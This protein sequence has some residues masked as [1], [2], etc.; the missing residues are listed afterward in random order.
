LFRDPRS[1][2]SLRVKSM[3]GRLTSCAERPTIT[4]L[5]ALATNPRPWRITGGAPTASIATDGPSPSVQAAT[6]ASTS[7]TP[8]TTVRFR[9]I[10][11]SEF[12]PRRQEVHAQ[13]A[14]ASVRRGE[15]DTG[16]D[17]ARSHHDHPVLRADRGAGHRLDGDRDRLAEGDEVRIEIVH[18]VKHRRRNGSVLAESPIDVGAQHLEVGQQLPRPIRQG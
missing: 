2:I 9:P 11:L 7:S 4:T 13:D 16:P 18:R 8:A 3:I 6:A 14:S 10:H 15:A 5:P 12:E 1:V 17:G